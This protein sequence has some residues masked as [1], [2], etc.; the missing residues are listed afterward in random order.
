MYYD[1][2]WGPGALTEA[3]THIYEYTQ[4]IR[5]KRIWYRAPDYVFSFA[6]LSDMFDKGYLL[7]TRYSKMRILF[8]QE[9]TEI[10]GHKISHTLVKEL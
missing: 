4:K 6:Y 7:L 8:V 10:I 5:K 9:I 3:N 1:C 2:I